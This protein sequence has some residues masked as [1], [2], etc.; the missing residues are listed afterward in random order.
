MTTVELLQKAKAELQRRGWFQGDFAPKLGSPEN[1][2]CCAVGAMRAA[3][4]GDP[5]RP[6]ESNAFE[7]AM[8]LMRQAAG[9]GRY[10]AIGDDWNDVPGRTVDYVLATF[11]KAIA[12][13]ESRP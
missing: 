4:T 12:L 8:V 13:A 1:C 6:C 7:D 5:R 9:I 10:A 11:D 2:P 3:V